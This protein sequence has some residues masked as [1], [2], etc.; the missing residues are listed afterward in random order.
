M[1]I[2]EELAVGKH[3]EGNMSRRSLGTVLAMAGLLALFGCGGDDGGGPNPV[4]GV[5]IAAEKP[6]LEIGHST[7]ITATV[8]GGDNKDLTWSV[9]GVENGDETYGTITQNSTVTYTAP[10]ALPS[11]R[12]VVIKAVSVADT[13]KVDTCRVAVQFTKLFVDSATGNDETATG[14][15]NIPYRTITAA[16]DDATEGITILV[17]PGTYTDTDGEEFPMWIRKNISLVGEDWETCIVRKETEEFNGYEGIRAAGDNATVRK[18]TIRDNALL[19]TDRYYASLYTDQDNMLIDS[20][21]VL[22][23]GRMACVR[24]TRATG[25]IV[26]NCVF[27]VTQDPPPTKI[28]NRGFEIVTET[29]GTVVRNCTMSGFNV[30]LFFNS[31]TNTL[32]EDCVLEHCEYGAELCCYNSSTANPSP[33]FGGGPRGSNG[34]NV[35]RYYE[36]CGLINKGNSTVY[37]KFN[38]WHNDPPVA[39]EDYCVGGD[40]SIIVE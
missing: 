10:D 9:N 26:Q 34:G 25:T 14:C 19:G 29:Q 3:K 2:R 8:S 13:G 20:V 36:E 4:T 38:A 15:I 24:I 33:D 16:I 7:A 23:H 30:A 37:A 17:R 1:D 18:L 27:D 32:V 40:G 22:E 31:T 12:T 5:D 39:G 11:P 21:R 35:F 28:M 6:N